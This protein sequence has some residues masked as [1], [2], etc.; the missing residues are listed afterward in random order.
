LR[1]IVLYLAVFALPYIHRIV[2]VFVETPLWI[3]ELHAAVGVRLWPWIL[4]FSF[5][6]L[7]E[8]ID[9]TN[10]TSIF[11]SEE[12]CDY[13]LKFSGMQMKSEFYF[14]LLNV[15]KYQEEIDQGQDRDAIALAKCTF[16]DF[17]TFDSP[18]EIRGDFHKIY[19][20]VESLQ[21]DLF[22]NVSKKALDHVKRLHQSFQYSPEFEK[23]NQVLSNSHTR[24]SRSLWT[25]IID[26]FSAKAQKNKESIVPTKLFDFVQ[27]LIQEYIAEVKRVKLHH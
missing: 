4:I 5:G 10:V 6:S 8:S 20:Q 26:R 3:K 18:L 25:D 9:T 22:V 11:I 12:C 7:Q 16:N 17:L 21:A 27:P 19:D 23:L 24:K 2:E 1:Y 15:A 13:F 14:F